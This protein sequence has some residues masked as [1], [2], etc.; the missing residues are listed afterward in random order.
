LGGVEHWEGEPWEG[1][2]WEVDLPKMCRMN[3][4]DYLGRSIGREKHWQ[5]RELGF[6]VRDP[7]STHEMS[8]IQ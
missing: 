8:G 5:G 2:H 6:Y 4:R 1:E 7:N 3:T